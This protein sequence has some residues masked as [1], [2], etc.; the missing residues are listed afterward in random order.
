[1]INDTCPPSKLVVIHAVDWTFDDTPQSAEEQFP[2]Y[3]AFI[4]GLLLREDDSV[5]VLASQYFH[6]DHSVR[7]VLTIPKPNIL[8]QARYDLSKHKWFTKIYRETVD[9]WQIRAKK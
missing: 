4:S 6:S 1:M 2:L 8:H 5:V 3:E 7:K 9:K